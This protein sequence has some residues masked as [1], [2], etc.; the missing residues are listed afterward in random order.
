ML[1]IGYSGHAFVIC[2]ILHAAAKKVTAYC[3]AEEKAINPFKL[4]Y[5]GKETDPPAVEAMKNS[6]FFI[7]IGDNSTRKKI[8]K[9]LEAME[10]YPVNAIHPSAIIDDTACVGK[11]G[12]MISAGVCIN[13]LAAIGNGAICN[14]GCIIEH[15]CV[16]GEFCHIGPGAVL[17]GNVTVGDGTFVGAA[18]VIRQG[19]SIGKDAVIGAG[20]VVVKN[21]RDNEVVAGNPSKVLRSNN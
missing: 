19:I 4:E 21:I 14:T 18:A 13:P 10:L 16:V 9:R 12:I 5:L 15:E 8:Y 11:H 20:A 6:G 17:C 2:G 1:I 3:D 7:S